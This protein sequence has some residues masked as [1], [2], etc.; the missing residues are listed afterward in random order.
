MTSLGFHY[1]PDDT[2]YRQADLQA[3]LPE[4]LALDARWLTLT[5]SLTRAIPEPFIRRLLEANIEPIIH[6]P[7]VP[8]RRDSQAVT[9]ST[10][11]MLFKNY[12][13]WGVRYVVPFS[14][15]NT[16]AAWAPA[17]WGQAGLVQRFL[18]QLAPLLE[19]QVEVGLQPV[20]P[21]LKAGGEYWDTAFL[22][23][24]LAELEARGKTALAR[25]LTFA[26]NLWTFNRPVD[27]GAGGRQRWSNA[28]PYLTPPGSQ[29]QRGFRLFE[30]YDQL[31][32]ER[33][34]Q[35]RPLLCLAGGPTPGDQMDTN[36]PAV[37]PLWH[38]SCTQE[39]VQM[40]GRDQLPENLLNVNFWL[41][42]APEG[43]PFVAEAWFRPDGTTLP[44]VDALKGQSRIGQRPQRRQVN[45]S[46]AL[47]LG[48]LPDTGDKPI[49]HYLLLP[50]F[51]WG[52][53]EHH[54][55]AALAYVN[56]HHPAL[57]FSAAEAAQA[58]RVTLLGNEQ[59]ISAEVEANLRRAGCAVERIALAA[60][61]SHTTHQPRQPH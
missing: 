11:A 32:R 24:A 44:A 41:L 21:A 36:F 5:G 1:Y 26:V 52:V 30:W 27:W 40:I 3:W 16:R 13:R 37:T 49:Q 48:A 33:L 15:P 22:A 8:L 59:G 2:H 34:G 51:E 42:T 43:S 55:R 12:A 38:A 28:R 39:I 9:T 46:K 20:F 56:A 54:W 29:D 57:G 35:P 60:D 19:A 50:V 53:S 6:L 17:D 18:D 7:S 10:L 4:L 23:G 25:Q 31:I 61:K 45:E 14:E 58:K 47:S